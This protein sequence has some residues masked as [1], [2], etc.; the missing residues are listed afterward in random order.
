M[1]VKTGILI[2]CVVVSHSSYVL[3]RPY[4]VYL[5]L[6]DIGVQSKDFAGSLHG[7]AQHFKCMDSSHGKLVISE[8]MV[9]SESLHAAQQQQQRDKLGTSVDTRTQFRDT[10]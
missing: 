5:D 7:L 10:E 9:I 2:K 4:Y 3:L 6:Q 1:W 8:S